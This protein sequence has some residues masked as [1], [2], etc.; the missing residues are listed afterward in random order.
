M[1]IPGVIPDKEPLLRVGIILPEDKQNSLSLEISDLHSTSILINNSQTVLIS[2]KK[3][4]ISVN[5]TGIELKGQKGVESVKTLKFIQTKNDGFIL[6]KPVIAG[7]G[8]HWAKQ[9][10]VKLPYTIEIEIVD[11]SLLLV[12]EL[13][14][15][16]YLACVATSEMG[17]E[18]PEAFIEA[19][20]IVARSWM[21]AN[22]EQKHVNLGF[23]VCN[24]DCCQRYQGINNLTTQSKA[25]AMNT[26]GQVLMY[27]SKIC[28][29]RY[30]KSCGGI[31][32]KFENLWED[33][34]LPYM[35]NIPDAKEKFDVDLTKEL[36]MKKWVNSVPR[37]FCSPHYIPENQL[38]K[39][40]GNVDEE[41][42][43]FRW[44]IK[45]SQ[46]ELVKN[47]NEKLKLNVKAVLSLIP[48]KRA[49]SGR[50]LELEIKYIDS[51]DN[52]RSVIIEKDYEVRRILHKMFLFSSAFII[53]EVKPEGSDYPDEFIF[54]GAGWGHGAGLCQIGAL[55]MA[56]NGYETKNIVYHYYPGSKLKKLY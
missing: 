44:T 14:L 2:D 22:I 39:Y 54:K 40:L 16:F 10:S 24:D 31:I 9:I 33:T 46:Q 11:N 37:T 27:D 5:E 45:T 47:I 17:A 32:E 53:E 3:I 7:R 13:P 12:N 42:K 29:A 15:E 36:E 56:L 1:L 18:C 49:G 20:T 55:G 21:L 6:V 25:G 8:F 30:S 38:K 23:D 26:R 35:Q 51:N 48:L 43:Y 34:P 4:E 50:M 41:G 19:Q 52:P 28:D